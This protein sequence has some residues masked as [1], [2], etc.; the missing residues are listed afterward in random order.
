MENPKAVSHRLGIAKKALEQILAHHGDQWDDDGDV[1]VSIR[2][3]ASTAL[4]DMEH[5]VDKKRE[6]DKAMKELEIRSDLKPWKVDVTYKSDT[7]ATYSFSTKLK[8]QS[9]KD[10]MWGRVY[11]VI[12]EPYFCEETL[13]KRNRF[14]T[15]AKQKHLTK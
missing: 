5:S 9:F 2:D 11:M 14:I 3:I 7:T 6:F 13:Q 12:S 8:A 10:N 1:L 4:H 15:E